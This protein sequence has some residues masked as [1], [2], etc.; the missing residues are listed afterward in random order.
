[1]ATQKDK[2]LVY[3]AWQCLH[4][5]QEHSVSQINCKHRNGFTLP[6]RTPK[7]DG[8]RPIEWKIFTLHPSRYSVIEIG[9]AALKIGKNLHVAMFAYRYKDQKKNLKTMIFLHRPGVRRD[10]RFGKRLWA[11]DHVLGFGHIPETGN[12]LPCWNRNSLVILWG[13]VSVFHGEVGCLR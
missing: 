6:T 11:R 8:S 13:G 10:F 9:R 5:K 2:E 7:E 3:T 4:C 1:M 12:K